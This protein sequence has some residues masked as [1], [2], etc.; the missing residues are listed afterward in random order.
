MRLIR[1]K[2]ANKQSLEEKLSSEDEQ[3]INEAQ[4][5][6][7]GRRS[8]M[9]MWILYTIISFIVCFFLWS[10]LF[11]IEESTTGEGKVIPVSKTKIIQSR[12]G[13]TVLDI[14][15][16]EG[17]LVQK[18]QILIRLDDTRDKADF[19]QKYEAY[20][21]LLAKVSRLKAEAYK[22]ETITFSPILYKIKPELIKMETHLFNERKSNLK[23]ELL[24]LEHNA[25]LISNMIKMYEPLLHKGYA[26]KIEY[27]SAQRQLDQVKIDSLQKE[28]TFNESV[29]KDLNQ[30][31]TE[32]NVSKENLKILRDKMQDTIIYSPV[33]GII[34]KINV[35]TI[36]GTIMPG[37][38]IMEIYPINDSLLVEVKIR[39][40]D[41][42]FIHIGAR[43]IVKI[44]AY[45]YTI[46]GDLIGRVSYVSTDTVEEKNPN[47]T[48]EEFYIVHI[49]TTRNYL[50]TEQ[51]KLLVM[52]GMKAT[53]QIVTGKKSIF[54]YLLK[55]LIK[56]K[57]EALRE[58]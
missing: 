43:A 1:E 22:E 54:R 8:H 11:S 5:A 21:A 38:E 46:Y 31:N 41:I 39:P 42:A 29:W 51:N 15:V 32:L 3:F 18:G 2:P 26:S 13:G 9:A 10:I 17:Q 52:P 4:A 28:N 20:L 25:D 6:V 58:R 57:E 35:T 48:I 30:Y 23:K 55:P 56:A 16:V 7:L 33:Y 19:D 24:L 45:D 12:D 49:K 14:P 27:L 36:G 47:N 44:S 40:K 53:V 34:N 50:G 37:M